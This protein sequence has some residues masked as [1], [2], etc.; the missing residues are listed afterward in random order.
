LSRSLAFVQI[1]L[2]QI[3]DHAFGEIVRRHKP[4]GE[5]NE[6]SLSASFH[7]D[8]DEIA[9]AIVR[10][11]R[12]C[13]KKAAVLE[14][15]GKSDQVVNIDL[16]RTRIRQSVAGNEQ[17]PAAQGLGTVAIGDPFE[18]GNEAILLRL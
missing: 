15:N 3:D 18:S 10:Y 13:A 16:I 6:D 12:H 14:A 8:F 7:F 4:L 2:R 17:F 9:C 5:G 11:I 1:S